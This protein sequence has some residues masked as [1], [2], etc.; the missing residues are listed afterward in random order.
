MDQE[1]YNLYTS[2]TELTYF[3]VLVRE[4]HLLILRQYTFARLVGHVT[5][6]VMS[7]LGERRESRRR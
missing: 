7:L 5:V 1:G 4:G 6:F 3:R 2:K